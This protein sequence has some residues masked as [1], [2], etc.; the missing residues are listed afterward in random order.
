LVLKSLDVAG[1]NLN[2]GSKPLRS[3][4][5]FISRSRDKLKRFFKTFWVLDAITIG[6]RRQD[7]SQSQL[8]WVEADIGSQIHIRL[9]DTIT[10]FLG[11]PIACQSSSFS[12]VVDAHDNLQVIFFLNFHNILLRSMEYHDV[13]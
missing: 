6:L 11:L 10:S 3:S 1:Y 9:K 8:A 4:S 7:S 12:V 5:V 13:S 2:G